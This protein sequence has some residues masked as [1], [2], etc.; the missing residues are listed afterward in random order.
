MN[1]NLQKEIIGLGSELGNNILASPWRE[2]KKKEDAELIK[3]AP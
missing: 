1:E 2:T 3:A